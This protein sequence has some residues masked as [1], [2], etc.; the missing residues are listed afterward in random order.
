MMTLLIK[1]QDTSSIVQNDMHP[2]GSASEKGNGNG[3]GSTHL[4]L[5]KLDTLTISPRYEPLS[6]APE[7]LDGIKSKV[8]E[9]YHRTEKLLK[10]RQDRIVELA[11]DMYADAGDGQV[12]HKVSVQAVHVNGKS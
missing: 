4:A 2:I 11:A 8:T 7:A 1:L 3:E 12:E 5:E 6:D 9:T 10:D